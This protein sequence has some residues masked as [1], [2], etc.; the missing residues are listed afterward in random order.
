MTRKR[1]I[2]VSEQ[3]DEEEEPEEER[4]S[5]TRTDRDI[6][7]F[8]TWREWFF[9]VFLKYVFFIVVLFLACVVPL[10][11]HRAIGGDAGLA[12]GFL[13]LFIIIPP[14]IFVYFRLW[15]GEG[16]KELSPPD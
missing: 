5:D 10:D 2:V 11:V 14:A 13:S 6:A 8:G 9:K 7:I 16:E 4:P 15:K 3:R 1:R 12:L